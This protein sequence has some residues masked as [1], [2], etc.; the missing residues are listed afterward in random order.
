MQLQAEQYERIVAQ[1]RSERRP[2]RR[3]TPRVGLRALVQL[4]PCRSGERAQASSAWLRDL[5]VDSI[6]FI[7][8]E[9]LAAGTY[10]VMMLPR[11]SGPTLDLLFKVTR[12]SQLN[13]SQFSVG[14][15]FERV[16]AEDELNE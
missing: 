5:S 7:F 4:L 9:T 10:L 15:R 14:A 6:G 8:P 1:L 12:C 2:E 16:I 13:N 3:R 11:Q